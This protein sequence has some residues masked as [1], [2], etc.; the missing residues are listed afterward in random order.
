[1]Y[2]NGIIVR[3]SLQK[4]INAIQKVFPR[5]KKREKGKKKERDRVEGENLLTACKTISTNNNPQ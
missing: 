2:I 1:M 5:W 4:T 3:S